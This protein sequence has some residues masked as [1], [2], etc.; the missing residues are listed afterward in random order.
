[1]TH[2]VAVRQTPPLR[3]TAVFA[4]LLAL[5][6]V[7]PQAQAA[8]ARSRHNVTRLHH[9]VTRLHFRPGRSRLVVRGF[10]GARQGEHDYKFSAR[11]GQR[12]HIEVDDIR[13]PDYNRDGG[14]VTLYHITFPSGKQYGQKGY[15]PFSGRLTETGTYR[16]TVGINNMATNARHG[17]YRMILTRS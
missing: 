16:I 2:I 10:I 5:P 14:L 8:R 6:P 11:A 15:D 12:L 3:V 9:N 13:P 4:V 1:M 7:G 17:R